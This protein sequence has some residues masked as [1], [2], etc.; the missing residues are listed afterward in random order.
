MSNLYSIFFS[1]IYAS[2]KPRIRNKKLIVCEI[3]RATKAINAG[4]ILHKNMYC[5]NL[6]P[7]CSLVANPHEIA[8]TKLKITAP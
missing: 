7:V 4:K 1:T 3:K 2:K 6:F 5:C 8:P